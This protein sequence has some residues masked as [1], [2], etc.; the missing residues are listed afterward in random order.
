MLHEI[1]S[2][3]YN[4][5]DDVK[6]CAYGVGVGPGDP[7]LMTLKA[8][9][10][11]QKADVICCCGKIPEE[12]AAYRIAVRAVPEIAQKEIFPVS[13]PMNYDRSLHEKEHLDSA[14]RIAGY[15]ETGKDVGFLI[16]GDPTVYSSFNY[17][18]KILEGEGY[19]TEIISGV[20][21]FCAA[22]A[23]LNISLTEWQEQMHI[24]T[25]VHQ[26]DLGEEY[27]GTT[28]YMKIGRQ[29]KDLKM[30]TDQSKVDMYAV[31]NC[32]MEG[33]KVY[34]GKDEIPDRSDYFTTVIIKRKP[35]EL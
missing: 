5:C 15:L 22:A 17:Y 30:K 28:V 8:V 19:R 13:V 16:L 12:S 14:R 32:G 27:P 3:S 34:Y 18:K 31:K 25:A 20:P 6:G 1:S 33:E 7:E 4:E 11:L 23:R 29:L 24:V 9:R 21:S 35:E 26:K 2:R 10:I